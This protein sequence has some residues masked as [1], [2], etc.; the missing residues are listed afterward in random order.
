MLQGGIRHIYH[1]GN[2]IGQILQQTAAGFGYPHN[3]KG[4]GGAAKRQINGFADDVAAVIGGFGHG[5]VHHAHRRLR[6]YIAGRNQPPVLQR[7]RDHLSGAR[8]NAADHGVAGLSPHGRGGVVQH[9]WHGGV[10]VRHLP[11]NGQFVVAQR[12]GVAFFSADGQS[13]QPHAVQLLPYHRAPRR[14]HHGYDHHQRHADGDAADGQCRARGFA[15]QAF[16]R[17]SQYI[18]HHAAVTAVPLSLIFSG[19]AMI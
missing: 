9:Q 2:V 17:I 19:V 14:A 7:Q 1:A 8:V 4:L 13:S 16:Q 15:R 3:G 5:L 18:P 10:D 12:A 11:Q 6:R